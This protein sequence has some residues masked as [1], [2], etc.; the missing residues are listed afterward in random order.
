MAERAPGLVVAGGVELPDELELG[1]HVVIHEGVA[2]GPGCRLQDHVVVGKQP[3]L[4]A[5]SRSSRDPVGE[6]RLAGR[7]SLCTGVIVFAGATLEAGAILGDRSWIRE[8]SLI[9]PDA[10]F[11]SGVVVGADVS[12]G[13]RVRIQT[14][15]IIVTG[16]VVDDDVF[17]GPAVTT[18]N[19]GA[20]G[21]RRG[22]AAQLR[23]VALRR[24][25]RIGAGVTVLPG[26]EVGE[27]AVVGAG[28]LVT[29]DVAPRSIVMGVPAR[30]VGEV[31][32]GELLAPR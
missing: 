3:L 13:A 19:D 30:P 18:T 14:Y 2:I 25:C 9:G 6:T 1:A 5:R 8:R 23:G 22:A 26:V 11:G 32:D 20:L 4:S 31:P 16:S 12:I 7:V 17:V 15:S 27:E 28:A 29:R 24:A 10:T 21:R